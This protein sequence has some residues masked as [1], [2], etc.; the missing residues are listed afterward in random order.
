MKHITF[1]CLI[2]LFII[3]LSSS[4]VAQKPVF[5]DSPKY[6]FNQAMELFQKEKYGSAQQ[7]FKYVYE[8]TSDKQQDIK[9]NSYFYMGVC[10]ANLYNNDAIFLLKDFVRQYPVHAFVPEANYFLGKFFFY[11]K[12]YKKAIEHY[13]LIDERQIKKE[14]LAEYKFK[15]G[16][17]YFCT[18][19]LD[20]AKALL[21]EARNNEGP[22]RLRA[23]YYLAHIAYEEK[24]YQ[25]ALEDFELLKNEIEYRDIVPIYISQIYFLQG[26]YA[27]LIKTATPLLNNQSAK[28]QPEMN[29]IIGLSHY[30]LG[31]YEAALPYFENYVSSTKEEIAKNDLFAIGYSLYETQNYQKSIEYLSKTTKDKDT[32][33]QNSFYIIGDCYLH[34]NQ[35]ALASQS[36]LE[37]SK[38]D[39]NS[40]IKE[41]ALYNYAKLQFATSSSPFNSAIKALENYINEYPNS[42]RSE[43]ANSY[44]S[45][46]YLSTKN[47]QGAIKSLENIRSKSPELLY[48]YQRCTHF[49]AMELINNN[50]YREA[51]SLLNK[52]LTYPM[53]KDLRLSSQYWKA[54][55][56]YRAGNYKEAYYDFQ[57]YHKNENSSHDENYAIS[58]YSYGY[59]AIKTGQYMEAINAFQNF[60][61]KKAS[62]D[63]PEIEADAT[64]RL[65]DSYFM[66][67][68]LKSAIFYYEKCEKMGLNNV[69][70]ALYQQSKCYGYMK[71]QDKKIEKLEKLIQYYPRSTYID[72]S[73]YEL[74]TTYHSQNNYSMAISAY[75]NFISKYPKSQLIRQAYNKLAQAYIN[76]QEE[77]LA[78]A[79]FK[80]VFETYPGSQEAKDAM[81]NLE[82]IYTEEGNTGEFF[83]YIKNKNMNISSSKQ[84]SISYK[85]AETKYNRGDCEAA[86][87]SF[88]NYLQQFPNGL[89]ASKAYFSKAECEYG[90]NNFDKAL[91]DYEKLINNYQTE[92]NETALRKAA[93]ILYNEKEYQKAMTYFTKLIEIASTQNHID[94]GN[95]GLMRCAF[96]LKN[97]RD[98]L[99][100][101]TNIINSELKDQDLISEAELIAGKSAMEL[102]EYSTAKKHLNELAFASINDISAE[103][104]YLICLIEFKEG[105]LE[106]C[107]KKITDMLAGSYSSE[108]WLASTFIL[109]G[110]LYAAQGNYFQA[111]YTYQS[112]VDNYTGED[113]VQIAKEKIVIVNE[114]ENSVNKSN[115]NQEESEE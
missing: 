11:K 110:D 49:R 74:A 1:N 61:K 21:N 59:S 81:A 6:E 109:Y 62:V 17:S 20:K 68:E 43:E 103:A 37:A 4:L 13:E 77:E 33:A 18:D 63:N 86:V 65:G 100:A 56:N 54:E 48:A 82:T 84:D 112:I 27:E 64:A 79:T 111:R 87:K 76:T 80:Y 19:E 50:E 94:Y 34:L 51:I 95:N 67:K 75:K 10:A 41:D 15:K 12:Q 24:Q 91:T 83:D 71:N 89:F 97:Y 23:V 88:E 25:A 28:N 55:S 39:Y 113:L 108:Y 8:N 66:Q 85:A 3:S 115:D 36:F 44:L 47:Y 40:E 53:N 16:Y 78:I 46:I 73:E 90:M 105:N 9:S 22:Y 104:A 7:Y 29:R 70:Y 102:G 92:Y 32:L 106:T 45:S 52:S 30:N 101:A 72:D 38:L 60:L 58:L 35:L 99:N 5:Y 114:L 2:S 93:T 107:E 14:D 96:E 31:K 42:S 26:R 57:S 98:A 69:D